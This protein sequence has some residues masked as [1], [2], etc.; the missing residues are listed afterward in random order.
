MPIAVFGA[1]ELIEIGF[2]EGLAHG[3]SPFLR[4]GLQLLLQPLAVAETGVAR[5]KR[6]VRHRGINGGTRDHDL[7]ALPGALR[8]GGKPFMPRKAEESA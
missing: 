3:R 5:I 4:F 2:F 8:V 1:G 7:R 6:I